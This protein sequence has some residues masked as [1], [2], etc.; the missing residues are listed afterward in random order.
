MSNKSTT[1]N[2]YELQRAKWRYSQQVYDGSAFEYGE[3]LND[4]SNGSEIL[5]S[6]QY[7]IPKKSKEN[8]MSSIK[9]D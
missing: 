9:K 3:G 1:Y 2:G 8:Q 5:N 7:Y 4:G 6:A